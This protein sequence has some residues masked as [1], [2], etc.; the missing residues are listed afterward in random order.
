MSIRR[1]LPPNARVRHPLAASSALHAP[2]SRL[3][4]PV[5]PIFPRE[6]AAVHKLNLG[7]PTRNKLGNHGQFLCSNAH[8]GAL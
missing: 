2:L 4:V 6:E 5:R 8:T 1:A 3:R 7:H